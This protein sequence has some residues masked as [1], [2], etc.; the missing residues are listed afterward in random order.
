LTGAFFC[1][2]RLT[3]PFNVMSPQRYDGYAP[4][5]Y[6]RHISAFH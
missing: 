3:E 6:L 2:A 1:D 5:A 4:M